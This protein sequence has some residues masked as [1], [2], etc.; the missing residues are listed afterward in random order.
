MR[1]KLSIALSAALAA[2]AS[3]Q[4]VT[5]YNIRDAAES[6]FGGWSHA[7]GGT[8]TNT[9][10]G[11]ANG[12]A[13]DRANY[14]GGS[15]TLN[16]GITGTG[17]ND[18]QLLANSSDANPRITLVLDGSYSIDDITM[19]SNTSGNSIPGTIRGCDVTING[20]TESFATSEP[21]DNDEFIDL[22]GSSLDGLAST[23]VT[24]SNFTHDGSNSLD[25]M[26][27]ISEI[28]VNGTPASIISSYG[29]RDAAESGFGA[30]SHAYDGT[31]TN[32]GSGSAN[33]FAFDRADYAGGSGTLNDGLPGTTEG[34][35]QLFANNNQAN[36]RI[37]ANLNGAY[38]ISTITLFSPDNSNSIP[39]TIRGCDVTINGVTESFLTSKTTAHNELID[40]GGSSLAGMATTNVVL[41]NFLH[42]G[43]NS[44]DEM[45]SIGEI[46][47][48]AVQSGIIGTYDID[49]AAESGFGGWSH[50]Y[51]GNITNTGSGSANGF[52]FDRADYVGGTGTLND[53]NPGTSVSD[54]Q[55]FANNREANPRITVNLDGSYTISN[56]TLYSFDA[57][58]SIPGT[59]RGCDVTIKG[60]TR[61][62]ATS[63][64]SEDDEFINLVGSALEGIRTSSITFSNFL[65]DGSNSL[66][67][68]FSIGEIGVSAT[69]TGRLIDF[70]RLEHVDGANSNHGATYSEDGFTIND[71]VDSNLRTFGTL[72]ARYPGST[73]LFDDTV[74]GVIELVRNDAGAYALERIDLAPLNTPSAVTVTFVGELGGGIVATQSHTHSGSAIALETFTFNSDFGN[75]DRVTWT[76]TAPF[77]QCDNIRVGPASDPGCPADLDGDGDADADDFFA[78][79]DAFAGGNEAVC[80]IDGDGDCDADDFFGYLDLFA[81][82]C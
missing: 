40:L 24:L 61:T 31:I 11:T 56:I 7:Y 76:Q 27:S 8:I 18:T 2:S 42:D 73:A 30:W 22:S 28:L 66:D 64:P 45:F 20:V 10:S 63:E 82:G 62:F 80:D 72:E 71:T 23:S 39:G 16:D 29:I 79:L 55:L 19:C 6:G 59:I 50:A 3:A 21:T 52:A 41:S 58:N 53:G 67:E 78:Y 17:I 12:F 32:T 36:P 65:H 4:T 48:K 44:L 26:F 60:V 35:T 54:T 38:R 47:F 68:M 81:Q 5:S 70:Q 74:N 51:G 1:K 15:G 57:G 25:E 75:V 14:S 13:F 33:G 69:P 77:Y 9:G 49:A 37:R 46:G 43:S 34:D